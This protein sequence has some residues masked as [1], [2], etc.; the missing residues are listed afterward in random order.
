MNKR[1]IDIYLDWV[2]NYLSIQKYADNYGLTIHEAM[3][4]ID[5]LR[6]AYKRHYD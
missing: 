5:T 6:K 2:N 1:L 4:L 3:I